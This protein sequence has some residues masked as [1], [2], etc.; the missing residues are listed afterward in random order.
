MC[1][2]AWYCQANGLSKGSWSLSGLKLTMGDNVQSMLELSFVVCCPCSS[3]MQ[4]IWVLR[5]FANVGRVAEIPWMISLCTQKKQ[6]SIKSCR[7]HYDCS[8]FRVCELSMYQP[9]TSCCKTCQLY[10]RS[11]KA[12]LHSQVHVHEGAISGAVCMHP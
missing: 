10:C 6:L 8:I 4:S 7:Y 5:K 9:Q 12:W 3:Q 2:I 11:K 1:I